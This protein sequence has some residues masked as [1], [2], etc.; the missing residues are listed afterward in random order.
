MIPTVS[1]VGHHD[2]GKTRII[3]RVIPMLVERGFRVGTV[4]DSPPLESID[5]PATDSP[6]TQ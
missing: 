3:S 1:I 6:A 2:S 5:A 4:N